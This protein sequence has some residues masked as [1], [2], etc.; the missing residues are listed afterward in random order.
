MKSDS[1]AD[2]ALSDEESLFNKNLTYIIKNFLT[3]YL[4]PYKCKVL[5]LVVINPKSSLYEPF[6]EVAKSSLSRNYDNSK[7]LV[8]HNH[9]R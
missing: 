9:S 3:I 1:E 4:Q 8:N 5:L 6:N 2:T 7:I